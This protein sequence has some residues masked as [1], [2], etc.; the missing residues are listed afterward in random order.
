MADYHQVCDEAN[1]AILHDLVHNTEDADI[2]SV[3]QCYTIGAS[4]K[5]IIKK[6][7][8]ANLVALKKSATYLKIYPE[9]D[10]K[11][12]KAEIITA[13]ITRI[14]SLLK[15]LCGVCGEY[16]NNLITDKPLFTCLICDQGCHKDCFE[17]ISTFFNALDENQKKCMQFICTSCH[18]DHKGDGKEEEVVVKAPKNLKKSPK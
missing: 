1:K 15:D 18:D 5:E 3:L 14:N 17:R 9:G 8:V 2:I 12:L 16:F 7:K 11:K 4:G 10:I 6:M 13:I